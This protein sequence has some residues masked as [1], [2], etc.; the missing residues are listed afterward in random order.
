MDAILAQIA[1]NA[2]NNIAILL[3]VAG[4]IGFYRLYREERKLERE[5]RSADA[6]KCAAATD[7]QTEAVMENAMV[8]RE[9]A[10]VMVDL[11]I[12]LERRSGK[13]ENS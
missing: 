12:A 3:L 8:I 13:G 6:A 1:A 4:F 5:A 9:H 11:R 2:S 10:R 7:R